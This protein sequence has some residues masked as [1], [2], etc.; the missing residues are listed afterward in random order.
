M[1][2]GIWENHLNLHLASFLLRHCT[3]LMLFSQLALGQIKLHH[4]Q[5]LHQAFLSFSV[6][7]LFTHL[8]KENKLELSLGCLFYL[9]MYT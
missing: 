1:F 6:Y 7:L 2:Q 4:I 8:M 5:I 9:C 3:M